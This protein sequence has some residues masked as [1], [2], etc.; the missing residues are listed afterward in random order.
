MI[1]PRHVEGFIKQLQHWTPMVPSS[2]N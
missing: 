1:E 2:S